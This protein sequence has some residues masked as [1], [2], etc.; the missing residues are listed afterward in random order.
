MNP[1]RDSKGFSLLEV[2]VATCLLGVGIMGLATLQSRGIR[3]NDLANRTSQAGSLAQDKLEELINLGSGGA[4]LSI[5]NPN[6][7]PDPNN[8]IN[9]TGGSGGIFARSWE[10]QNATPVSTSQSI[11]VTVTWNDIIGQHTVTAQAY[12]TADG[13]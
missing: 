6:P 5:P 13:Y 10:I 3:G 2:L 8:P 11:T 4:F 9:E 7:F 1:V 12:L